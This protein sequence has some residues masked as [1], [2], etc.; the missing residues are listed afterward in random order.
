METKV[1][2]LC[3]FLISV[4]M[5]AFICFPFHGLLL[6]SDLHVNTCECVLDYSCQPVLP[7]GSELCHLFM[8]HGVMEIANMRGVWQMEIHRAPY[9]SGGSGGQSNLHTPPIPPSTPS[10]IINLPAHARAPSSL[11]DDTKR[12][13][14]ISIS[15][16]APSSYFSLL[17]FQPIPTKKRLIHLFV[18]LAVTPLAGS[19]G[20][21]LSVK[22]ILR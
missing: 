12:Q 7:R 10:F 11:P 9:M 17:P 5:H 18:A 1:C 19:G 3:L 8:G 21:R 22:A 13:K 2:H 16:L 6:L 14:A 15:S 4:S 20:R